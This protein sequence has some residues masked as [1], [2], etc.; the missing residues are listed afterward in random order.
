MTKRM[1]VKD[2]KI[3]LVLTEELRR[4]LAAILNGHTDCVDI[5]EC[6]IRYM[7]MRKIESEN[8]CAENVRLRR[9]GVRTL[10]LRVLPPI[11]TEIIP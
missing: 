5:E 7:R 8:A 11:Q 9:I 1:L 3:E 2:V 6:S 4:K 10:Q